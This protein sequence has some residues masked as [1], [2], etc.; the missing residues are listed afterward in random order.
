MN[1]TRPGGLSPIDFLVFCG[2][3]CSLSGG[4]GSCSYGAFKGRGFVEGQVK[5]LMCS[6]VVLASAPKPALGRPRI[7]HNVYYVELSVERA[8]GWRSCRRSSVLVLSK[9][10]FRVTRLIMVAPVFV[11]AS[12]TYDVVKRSFLSG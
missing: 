12:I 1:L 6:G 9:P 7:A 10:F 5:N 11:G 3:G 4:R 8:I 2:G